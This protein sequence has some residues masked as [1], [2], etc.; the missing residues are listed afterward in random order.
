MART[1]P[2]VPA[3]AEDSPAI[4]TPSRPR[5]HTLAPLLMGTR[6]LIPLPMDFSTL[7][8]ALCRGRKRI[9]RL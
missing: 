3:G 7:L 8:S 9:T 2:R 4:P 6:A 5:A 1:L